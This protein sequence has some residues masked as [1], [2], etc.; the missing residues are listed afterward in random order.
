MNKTIFRSST[1]Y[2]LS[3]DCLGDKFC[4]RVYDDWDG[5]NF[6]V[7]TFITKEEAEALA[8]AL[9]RAIEKPNEIVDIDESEQS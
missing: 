1:G 7:A 5:G 2:N 4:F 3:V 9:Q 8:Q 6:G